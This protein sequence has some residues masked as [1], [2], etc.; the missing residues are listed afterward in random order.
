MTTA[1]LLYS[2][3]YHLRQKEVITD[4]IVSEVQVGAKSKGFWSRLLNF[5]KAIIICLANN[6]KKI[7]IP[8]AGS[9]DIWIIYILFKNRCILISDGLSDC[10]SNIKVFRAHRLLGFT[11]QVE[12]K[13]H[14]LNLPHQGLPVYYSH[15][16]PDIAQFSKRGR[17]YDYVHEYAV[18]NFIDIKKTKN[19]NAGIF[20]LVL[21]PASTIVFE[22][23]KSFPKEK[24]LVISH[25]LSNG[26]IP[27]ERRII[28]KKYEEFL[29][30]Q[31]CIIIR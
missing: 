21:V 14:V 1:I 22:L 6:R 31:G 9:K 2:T 16:T 8:R 24:I 10:L 12:P 26:E 11:K 20:C 19:P 29:E 7:Y 30:A 23:L 15:D 27:D 3:A 18:S 4:Q 17:D 28:L 25:S 5:L 13:F